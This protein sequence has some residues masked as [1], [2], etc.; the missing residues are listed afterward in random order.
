MDESSTYFPE[1][2]FDAVYRGEGPFRAPWDIDRPQPVFVAVERSG[3]ISGVVLD[4]GCGTGENALYL[5]DRGYRVTGVDSAPTAIESA[6]GK[7]AERG[8][9]AT[10]EVA[11]AFQLDNF[12]NTFD[13]VVDSALAHIFDTA[14]L[15]RYAASLHRA[16]RAGARAYVLAISGEGLPDMAGRFRAAMSRAGHSDAEIE[17][18]S[19]SIPRKS[20]DELRAG[21]ADHWR[22][23]SIERTTMLATLSPTAEDVEIG[24]WLGRFQRR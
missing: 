16:C 1:L 23:E 11:D 18:L 21:F 10:F 9:D 14:A 7:A 24:A 22:A 6:R 12:A 15:P 17:S 13:T 2:D 5:A 8:V 4:A 19:A 3:G 20:A